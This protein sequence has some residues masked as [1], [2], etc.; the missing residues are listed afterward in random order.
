MT[1]SRKLLVGYDLCEDYSQISY[2][3]DKMFETETI[4]YGDEGHDDRIPT[5]M[6][7]TEEKKEWLFG[8]AAMLSADLSEAVLVEGLLE[9]VKND[10][11]HVIYGKEFEAV[12]ILSRFFKKT[13]LLLKTEFPNDTITQIV[14]TI[15]ETDPILVNGIFNALKLLGLEKDRV[16]V[17]AH[18]QSY[19]YYAL[20]QK[21]ELWMNDVS[22][23]DF[24]RNGLKYHQI[25]IDRQK[26]PITVAIESCDYS[27]MLGFELLDVMYEEQL[28]YIFENVSRTALHKQIV[29]TIYVTGI[30]F[31]EHWAEETIKKLCVGRRGFIGQNLYSAGACYMAKNLVGED[32]FSDFIFLS[33]DMIRATISAKIYTDAT[34]KELIF[35]KMATPWYEADTAYEFILN[36]TNEVE[37][38]VKDEVKNQRKSFFIVLEGLPKRP[39]KTT[40]VRI[41]IKFLDPKTCVVSIKDLGFGELFKGTDRLWEKVIKI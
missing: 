36:E 3:N 21:K 19:M 30:G 8:E 41:S 38:I 4:K 34:D 24:D 6:A 7:V 29:S 5:V 1:D 11:P 35:A 20:S 26:R 39:E 32:K 13:L 33:K 15:E 9:H 25:K 23:F 40:R 37:I 2:Y 14:V 22:L 18:V 16:S 12:D 27:E 17:V 10:E 28:Q 31:E